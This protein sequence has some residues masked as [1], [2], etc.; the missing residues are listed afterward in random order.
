MTAMNDGPLDASIIDELGV[1]TIAEAFDISQAAVRKWRQTGIPDNRQDALRNMVSD[2]RN[3]VA[4]DAA[5]RE[6]ELLSPLERQPGL[7]PVSPDERDPAGYSRRDVRLRA[8][9]ALAAR[10]AVQ[11]RRHANQAAAEAGGLPPVM[12]VYGY[13][14]RLAGLFALDFPI[15]T[16]AFVAVTQVSPIV[17][18]G[19]A[20]AMSLFLVL[21]AHLL[22][23]HLRDM[24]RH[25]PPWVPSILGIAVIGTLIACTIAVTIDLRLKGFEIDALVAGLGQGGPVFGHAGGGPLTLPA[26]TQWSIV[27][28]AALVTIMSTVFGIGWSFQRHAPQASFALAEAAYARALKAYATAVHRMRAKGSMA[29]LAIAGMMGLGLAFDARADQCEGHHVLAFVDTTT[30]YDDRDRDVIMRAID[31]MAASLQPGQHLVMRTVRDHPESSRV[32]LDACVPTPAPFAWSIAGVIDWLLSNPAEALAEHQAFF[33]EARDALLPELQSPGDAD[34]TALVAT[35]GKYAMADG[36]IEA[37]W[38]FSDLL[39]SSAVSAETLISQSRSLSPL[40]SMLPPL[41]GATVHVAGLGRFHDGSRR[42]L[43]S[44]ERGRL[45]DSW[46]TLISEAGGRIDIVN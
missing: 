24:A 9:L 22:G 30:A 20:V 45:V 23:I 3:L 41:E 32:L 15:L 29:A 10:R 34:K 1:A 14:A 35:I 28:A 38:L 18:A 37:I 39:E 19:S 26:E 5:D 8:T 44:L 13:P 17:A 43:S 4:I 31:H 21:C 12:P 6:D 42:A 36:A 2:H 11:A 7:G 33:A 25:M 46:S 40:A 16:M 27:R